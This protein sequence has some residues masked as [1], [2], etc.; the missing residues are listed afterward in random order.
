M[1]AGAEKAGEDDLKW[2]ILPILQ[3]VSDPHGACGEV[4]QEL[5]SVSTTGMGVCIP[6][7]GKT[8]AMPSFWVSA[9]RHDAEH[10]G[11]EA[12]APSKL[13]HCRACSFLWVEC[14][15]RRNFLFAVHLTKPI[16]ESQNH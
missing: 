4:C 13:S 6:E 9:H 5:C 11:P 2:G 3:L 10:T 7:K 8:K 14:R 16:T 1:P 12:L 15:Q